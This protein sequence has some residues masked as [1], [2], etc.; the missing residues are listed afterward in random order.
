MRIKPYQPCY[1]DD[2]VALSLRA[3]ESVFDSLEQVLDSVL[4]REF[5]PDWRDSQKQ[6]VEA[7]C[8]AA[9]TEVWVSIDADRVTGFVAVKLDR[10]S[11]MGEIH[12]IAVEPDYQRCGISTALTEFA[13]NHMREVGMSVAMVETG[14]DPGHAPARRAYEKAGFSLFP[15][16]RYFRKL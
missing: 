6:A 10:D 4:Y 12:M 9:D 5:Y 15:V 8:A 3:W 1:L 11:R 16:A 13:L 7:A 14:G 2:V